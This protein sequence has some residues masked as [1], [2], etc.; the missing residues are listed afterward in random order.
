MGDLLVGCFGEPLAP[1][2]FNLRLTVV[3]A[4]SLC[5]HLGVACLVEQNLVRVDLKTLA[6]TSRP[7]ILLLTR[8]RLVKMVSFLHSHH[9]SVILLKLMLKFICF[10]N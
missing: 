4:G 6:D 5:F 10:P 2:F 3:I 8:L 9:S 1:E 7:F